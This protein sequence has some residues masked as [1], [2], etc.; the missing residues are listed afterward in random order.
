M[1]A[2]G[3]GHGTLQNIDYF[4]FDMLHWE[5]KYHQFIVSDAMWRQDLHADK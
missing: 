3:E 2:M 1:D 4:N 5:L